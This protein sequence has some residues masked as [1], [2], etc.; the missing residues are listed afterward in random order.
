M[1]ALFR[2]GDFDLPAADQLSEDVARMGIKIGCRK[3]KLPDFSGHAHAIGKR[4]N[5]V[6]IA[7]VAGL[8]G[9]GRQRFRRAKRDGMTT[10]GFLDAVNAVFP[11]AQVQPCIVEPRPRSER[12]HRRLAWRRPRPPPS[13]WHSWSW[14]C[15]LFGAPTPERAGV[16]DPETAPTEF[17]PLPRRHPGQAKNSEFLLKYYGQD[18]PGRIFTEGVPSSRA[19]QRVT[20]PRA[21]PPGTRQEQLPP[22]LDA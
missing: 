8:K 19:H 2:D 10:G 14:R 7:G 13:S 16:E 9:E 11:L 5:P 12:T 17:Q 18:D 15:L 21:R 3:R 6:P 20:K 4:S 1:A 22:T